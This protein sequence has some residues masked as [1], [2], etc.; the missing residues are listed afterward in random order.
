MRVW[1]KEELDIL[2]QVT[3]VQN[4][5]LNDEGE[6]FQDYP[7]WVVTNNNHVYLRAGKG[8]DSKW[9]K[10]GLKNG[11]SIEFNN[12]DYPINY[13]AIDDPA[14]IK[15]VTDAYEAKYHGQ[16]PIDMMVSDKCAAATV[17]LDLK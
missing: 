3:T 14:E 11:G 9:Y 16:Y 5:P 12:Q 13:V 7:I 1:T 8:K 2:N 4:H 17:R 6:S 15:A 10:A